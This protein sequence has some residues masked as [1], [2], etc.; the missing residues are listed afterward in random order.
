M[1]QEIRVHLA[2]L[3]E[4]WQNDPEC[5][6]YSK[7]G[8]GL[9]EIVASYPNWF[10]AGSNTADY[11]AAKPTYMVNVYSYLFG[12]NRMHYFESIKAAHDAVLTW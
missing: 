3:H 5:D 9:V 8:E 6:G 7:S 11:L 10:R 4:K 2:A 12:P 1:I